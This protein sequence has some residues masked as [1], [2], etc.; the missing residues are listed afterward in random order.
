MEKAL[1]ALQQLIE[2]K[3]KALQQLKERH[4]EILTEV[5]YSE[6]EL[7]ELQIIYTAASNNCPA[8]QQETSAVK[9]SNPYYNV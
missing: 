1:T 5:N 8:T 4:D 6:K 9:F 3:K 7:E 2:R